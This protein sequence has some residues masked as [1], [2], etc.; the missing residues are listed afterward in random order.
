MQEMF[1]FEELEAE[2]FNFFFL[3][4]DK[5]LNL[6]ICPTYLTKHIEIIIK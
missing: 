2:K 3:I 4:N 6:S 5:V 1:T